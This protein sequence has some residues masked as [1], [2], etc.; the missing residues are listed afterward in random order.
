VST[1]TRKRSTDDNQFRVTIP[2]FGSGFM[3]T[4][5]GTRRTEE[6]F[7]S[8]RKNKHYI[9]KR[10]EKKNATYRLFEW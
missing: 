9:N 10:D 1:S 3:V 8:V 2:V 5:V 6:M 7:V 4:L